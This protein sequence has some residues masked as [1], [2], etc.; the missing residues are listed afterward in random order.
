MKD[1]K[2]KD[3]SLWL[4][5]TILAGY[6][7]LIAALILVL[8]YGFA[9]ASTHLADGLSETCPLLSRHLPGTTTPLLSSVAGG[10]GTITRSTGQ[11]AGAVAGGLVGSA[12]ALI[13]VQATMGISNSVL[14]KFL[15]NVWWGGIQ[16]GRPSVQT[17]I[18]P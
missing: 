18:K 12:T 7:A 3:M 8:N 6:S 2:T 11:G 1:E 14:L 17:T 16:P 9:G 15:D 5:N 13:F 4:K 10:D